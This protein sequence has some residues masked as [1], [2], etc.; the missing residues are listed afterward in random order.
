M[1]EKTSYLVGYLY[2]VTGCSQGFDMIIIE[3]SSWSMI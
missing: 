1:I 2:L 3:P